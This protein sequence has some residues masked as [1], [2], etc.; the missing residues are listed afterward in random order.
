MHD[1]HVRVAALFE[2]GTNGGRARVP[3]DHHDVGTL[4]VPLI[5]RGHDEHDAFGH[6]AGRSDAVRR[7]GV[8]LQ[9][10]ELLGSAI[11]LALAGGDDDGRDRHDYGR[12]EASFSSAASVSTF[13][14]NVSSETRI[15]RARVSMRFSPAERP[16]SLSRI[17]RFRTTSATW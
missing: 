2:S 3:T 7:H 6:G 17:D 16:L 9:D 5:V 15:W 14:A 1:D 11:T 13:N 4:A 8:V 12:T 10:G